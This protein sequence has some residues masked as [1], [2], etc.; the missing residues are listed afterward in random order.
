[1]RWNWSL[2]WKRGIAVEIRFS[3]HAKQRAKLY[4]I[5]ASTVQDILQEMDLPTGGHE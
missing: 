5:P 3:R 4:G 1:M 2:K